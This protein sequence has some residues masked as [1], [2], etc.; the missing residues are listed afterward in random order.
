L[1]AYGNKSGVKAVAFFRFPKIF[2]FFLKNAIYGFSLPWH[3]KLKSL[4]VISN[5]ASIYLDSPKP[6]F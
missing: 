6:T 3:I 2:I 1:V 5:V 4:S